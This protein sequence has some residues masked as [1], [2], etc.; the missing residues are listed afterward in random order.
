M[1]MPKGFKHTQET[2]TKMSEKHKGRKFTTEHRKKLSEAQMGEKNSF[3][4]KHHTKEIR[5]KLSETRRGNK[6]NWKGGVTESRG[7]IL[8]YS[9]EHPYAKKG[10]YIHR[11]RLVMEE[12]L[13]RYLLPREIVHHK[14]EITNDDYPRNLRLFN[15]RGKH[16]S[17]HHKQRNQKQ[18]GIK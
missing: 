4:G 2:K 12:I 5:K 3:Y 16:I 7:R 14:N 15:S 10:G 8:I 13:G 17:F 6:N 18:L 1:P 11:S 9:P